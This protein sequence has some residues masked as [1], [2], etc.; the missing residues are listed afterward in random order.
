MR[1]RKLGARRAGESEA[2]DEE[3]SEDDNDTSQNAPPKLLVHAGFDV[4][5]ALHEIL[6]GEVQRVQRPDVK[7]G[8]G[9]G[10]RE[11]DQKHQGPCIIRLDSQRGNGVD[12]TKDKVRNSKPSDNGH[13]LA[14][15]GLD[16]T[17]AHAHNQKQKERKRVAEG[18]ENGNNNHQHLGAEVVTMAVLVVVEAPGHQHLEDQEDDDSRDVILDRK[19][20][21]PVLEVEK[22]PEHGHDKVRDGDTTIEGQLRDL[23]GWKLSVRVPEGYDGLVLDIL[24][25]CSRSHAVV[26]RLERSHLLSVG[27]HRIL[28]DLG[29]VEFDCEGT[30]V[31]LGVRCG[32]LGEDPLAPV[33][34]IAQLCADGVV[35]TDVL[36]L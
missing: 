29:L 16:Y 8:Q 22:A 34:G 12:N 3:K 33:G 15:S 2:V 26:S 9:R 10:E 18:V 27:R 20:I 24:C 7:G 6:H 14:E 4:L 11:N 28:D 5:L 35:V 13:R 32:I 21:V 31:A 25:E 1:R 19:D 23:R 30:D 17:I 36:A